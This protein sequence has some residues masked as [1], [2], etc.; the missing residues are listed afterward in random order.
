MKKIF[1]IIAFLPIACNTASAQFTKAELQV[2]GL[3]CSLCSKSTSNQLQKL[4]FIDSIYVDLAHAT[5]ILYFKKDSPVNFYRI[6]K[7]VKDAGFSVA[8]L[9]VACNFYNV[10][11]DANGCFKY[12]QAV[13]CGMNKPPR[14]LNGEIVLQIIDKGFLNNKDY[15]KYAIKEAAQPNNQ[16][17]SLVYHVTF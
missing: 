17:N 12:Q 13:F 11:I 9:K 14:I 15:K 5:F 7:K 10:P 2:A 16:G 8:M 6:K 4:D 3:T 1:Y